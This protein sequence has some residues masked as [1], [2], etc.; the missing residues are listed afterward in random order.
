MKT[1]IVYK[2][3]GA[4]GLIQASCIAELSTRG[5]NF[6][7]PN[8]HIGT[9]VGAINA[10]ALACGIKPDML[11]K[12]YPDMLK[13][14]FSSPLYPLFPKY[15][16]EKFIKEWR[17]IINPSIKLKSVL[18]RLIITSVDRR[19][20]KPHFFKSWEAKDGELKL[21]DVICRSFAA[22]YYFGQINDPVE[23]KI[24]VDG[25][26]GIDNLPLEY[27]YIEA[28][29]QDWLNEP[30]TFL[31]IGTGYSETIKPYKEL[32]KEGVMKQLKDFFNLS[33]G[34]M[35][36]VMSSWAQ[37]DRVLKQIDKRKNVKF[38]YYDIQIPKAADG[39]DKIK[40]IDQYIQWGKQMAQKPL[41]ERVI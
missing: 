4:K 1:I 10:A 30:L 6:N 17:A 36:R 3:G 28:D 40:F 23:Q 38:L 31:C 2:G 5:F 20:D 24:W 8:L 15:K 7:T 13:A 21:T 12:F 32:A 33:N 22:P 41:I 34:G 19:T 9:S 29:L 25:G 39:M 37:I 35:A 16:R 14:I 27:A 26:C 18:T 11:F